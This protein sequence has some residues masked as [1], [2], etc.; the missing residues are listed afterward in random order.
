M[1][2]VRNNLE[3]V[4]PG[5]KV[6]MLASKRSSNICWL[7]KR[8]AVVILVSVGIVHMYY[9]YTTQMH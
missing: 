3:L 6:L 1:L 9:N 2:G 8:K 5:S 4:L 7:A